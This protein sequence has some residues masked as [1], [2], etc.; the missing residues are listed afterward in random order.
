[1][2]NILSIDVEEIFHT[3]LFK[4]KGK[5]VGREYRSPK[6]L[7]SVFE[8]LEEYDAKATFFVDGEIAEEHPGLINSIV[9]EG[10]EVAYH[11]WSHRTLWDIGEAEFKENLDRFLDLH[12]RCIGFRA[13]T[14]SLDNTTSWVLKHLEERGLTYDSSIFPA[15]TPLYGVPQAPIHPYL[16]MK[17]NVSRISC[18]D[19]SIMEYPLLIYQIMGI[20]LPAA[21]GFYLRLSPKL[22]N[23]ALKKMN[24]E[25]HPGVIYLHTWE[26]DRGLKKYNLGFISSK[27]TYHNI[28]KT[29]EYLRVLLR[30]FK[31]TSFSSYIK[32]Q[33]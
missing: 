12:P 6:I 28:A 3:H 5:P 20:R 21:G 23:M 10:H 8:M 7:P 11:G 1:M 27:I 15:R 18:E 32:T 26:L 4:E 22:V 31:F 16:P 30:N 13:P 2:K 29:P 9:Y 24:A 14:F 25:G 17:D 33:K 19:D